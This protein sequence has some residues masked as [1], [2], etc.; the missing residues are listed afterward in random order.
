MHVYVHLTKKNEMANYKM[1][2]VTLTIVL[3]HYLGKKKALINVSL[4]IHD[5]A[6]I[7]AN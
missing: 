6:L 7:E 4:K 5:V 2:F 3:Y 1:N